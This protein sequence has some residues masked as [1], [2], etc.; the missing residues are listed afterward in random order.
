[1]PGQVVQLVEGTLVPKNKLNVVEVA[2]LFLK[3]KIRK[4]KDKFD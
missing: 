4:E 3:K 1:M 2:Y